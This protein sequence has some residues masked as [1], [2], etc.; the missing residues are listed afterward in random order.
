MVKPV[1]ERPGLPRPPGTET[2]IN[3]WAA[4]MVKVLTGMLSETNYRLNKML[5][6]DGTERM[7]AP[8]PLAV[9]TTATL[10][11]AALWQGGIV[12]VSD[13]GS[14]DEFQ[15][16]DGS[17]W[18]SFKSG[19]ATANIMETIRGLYVLTGLDVQ[20]DVPY[21][22]AAAQGAYTLTGIAATTI[23]AG[24]SADEWNYYAPE[25]NS[26]LRAVPD[27]TGG[28]LDTG[29]ITLVETFYSVGIVFV[30]NDPAHGG[31]A[32][33]CECTYTETGES[34]LEALPLY[35]D[36]RAGEKEFRG[37]VVHMKENTE[38]TIR[39]KITSGAGS[40]QYMSKVFTTWKWN[41]PEEAVPNYVAVNESNTLVITAGMSG[42][43]TA[44]AVWTFDPANG[45][46]TIDVADAEDYCVKIDG[47]QYV[48]IK[49]VSL[50]NPHI[51]NVRFKGGAN[52][53]IIEGCLVKGWGR[54]GVYDFVAGYGENKDAAFCNK[55]HAG[56]GSDGAE[57]TTIT[58]IVI[59]RCTINSPRYDSNAWDQGGHPK[60]PCVVRFADT[61]GNH[62][63]GYNTV[64]SGNGNKYLDTLQGGDNTSD[65]GY[66]GDNSDIFGSIFCGAWDD[67]VQTEGGNRNVRVW[68]NYFDSNYV[69]IAHTVLHNGPLYIWRNVVA[70]S[71][72]EAAG[73]QS[74]S[75][76]FGKCQGLSA[77][78][79]GGRIY[80]MFNTS[81]QEDGLLRGVAKGLQDNGSDDSI[82]NMV[83]RNNL[84]VLSGFSN[85]RAIDGVGLTQPLN[86]DFDYDVTDGVW[87]IDPGEIGIEANGTENSTNI[88]FA[89]GTL[90][91]G[92]DVP[93]GDYE[94]RSAATASD[95]YAEGQEQPNFG[96]N[97]NKAAPCVGAHEG[98]RANMQFGVDAYT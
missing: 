49:T 79:G 36:V 87:K 47:A 26:N 19:L 58:R 88:V 51:S 97:M 24:A 89:S 37:S 6:K 17:Q 77:G 56:D 15:G 27:L 69:S 60:G 46:A 86:N 66:P 25:G 61:P 3:A 33:S 48:K 76:K 93:T 12:F 29:T 22:L 81:L 1:S 92:G 13:A 83:T 96:A 35:W 21:I 70:R 91:N 72:K 78:W 8:L 14:G 2:G 80:W 4:D 31:A 74:G 43:P 64:T 71:Q 18:L 38:Y 42:T 98:G 95:G 54:D 45:S 10:P 82:N 40:G 90:V 20:F 44:W 5:P 62:V 84:F 94:L 16:S 52:W 59:R 39:V 41:P 65:E 73:W 32:V 50:L 55:H 7:T 63:F 30:P 23:S 53:I 67:A 11:A 68:G 85:N 57:D 9:Y 34:A 75:E 28:T